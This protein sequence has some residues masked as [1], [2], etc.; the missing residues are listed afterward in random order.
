MP[1]ERADA[2]RALQEHF[3][4]GRLQLAEFVER[5]AR[6][7]DAVTAAELTALFADL[8]APPPKLP[9]PLSGVRAGTSWSS[10]PP[11]CWRSS[12]CSAS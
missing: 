8:P 11:S 9:E 12:G 6:A 1:V 4:A 10:A 2:Q 5:F 3:N 7:A